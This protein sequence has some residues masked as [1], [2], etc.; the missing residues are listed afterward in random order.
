M[1]ETIAVV[2]STESALV[3]ECVG[4]VAR[5]LEGTDSAKCLGKV[6]LSGPEERT[7]DGVEQIILE[8]SFG[9]F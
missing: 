9:A 2:H 3:E 4:D 5:P 6:G 7:L 1:L 8:D